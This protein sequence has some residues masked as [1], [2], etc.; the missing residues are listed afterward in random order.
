MPNHDKG[1][2][3]RDSVYTYVHKNSINMI[4]RSCIIVVVELQKNPSPFT[5]VH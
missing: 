1:V 4:I 3:E 2:R 5:H